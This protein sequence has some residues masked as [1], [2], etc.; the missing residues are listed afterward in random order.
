MRVVL[1]CMRQPGFLSCGQESLDHVAWLAVI[2]RLMQGSQK[3]KSL[4]HCTFARQFVGDVGSILEFF[5]V[6]AILDDSVEYRDN[7][8][9]FSQFPPA[10][11]GSRQLFQCSFNLVRATLSQRAFIFSLFLRSPLFGM[12]ILLW[13]SPSSVAQWIGKKPSYHNTVMSHQ[14]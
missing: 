1:T 5:P 13:K 6:S 3:K 8:R 11:T 12:P 10:L 9:A 4:R 14:R 2:P 7:G